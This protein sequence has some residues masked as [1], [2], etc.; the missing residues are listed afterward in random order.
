M[1]L[2]DTSPESW[3]LQHDEARLEVRGA[4][5]VFR[6]SCLSAPDYTFRVALATGRTW[7]EAA[8]RALEL[9]A[10]FDPGA[11]LLAL[12]NERLVTSIRPETGDRL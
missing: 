8:A 12:I 4:R 10:A 2:T 9:D 3:E 1:Y 7:G 6:F 11:A 5:G